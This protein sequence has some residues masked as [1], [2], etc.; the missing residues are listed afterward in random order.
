MATVHHGTTSLPDLVIPSTSAGPCPAGSTWH[1]RPSNPV[2][3][4][5][6][7]FPANIHAERVATDGRPPI[8]AIPRIEAAVK[9]AL[10]RAEL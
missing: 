2:G 3:H 9:P 4:E 10:K 6:T 5:V 8:H 1:P 7:D